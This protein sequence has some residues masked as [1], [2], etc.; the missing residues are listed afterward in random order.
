MGNTKLNYVEDMVTD[1]ASPVIRL[2]WSMDNSSYTHTL[3]IKKGTTVILT[4]TGLTGTT[5]KNGKTINLT[6]EQRAALLEAMPDSKQMTVTYALTTYSGSAQVG[7]VSEVSAKLKTSDLSKPVFTDFSYFDYN[8]A[9]VQITGDS[10][11]LIRS[12]S[13]LRVD[14]TTAAGLNGASITGYR[15]KVGEKKINSNSDVILFG[16]V[17]YVGELTLTVT[18]I[19]SRGYETSVSVPV[20][21]YNYEDIS[22]DSYSVKRE[23]NS[24]S[25]VQVHIAG[26]I[27]S[28]IVGGTEKNSFESAEYRYKIS[29]SDTWSSFED[30]TNDIVTDG[31][32]F[33]FDEDSWLTLSSGNAYD[34]QFRFSDKLSTHT[35][36]I[37]L[38]QGQPLVSFRSAKVGINTNDPQSALDVNGNI[39]MNGYNVLGYVGQVDNN[40]DFDTVTDTGIYYS[41]VSNN[42]S[43]H[44]P[45]GNAG[46][47]EVIQFS[48]D[49]WVQ[50]YTVISGATVYIRTKYT[51]SWGAWQSVNLT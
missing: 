3:S 48:L 41:S 43:N 35:L 6:S 36:T 5:S 34:I 50:R 37:Y 20:T 32:D 33:T 40:T 8:T 16:T 25:T 47:L 27:S 49:K 22:V 13:L 30:I 46:L 39:R 14:C 19:D 17:S 44:A 29:S 26:H 24:G 2:N 11:K 23:N 7:S 31:T 21:V 38:A 12:K 1:V 18:A 9:T 4:I 42:S 45:V 28:V 15:A 10:Q 51:G